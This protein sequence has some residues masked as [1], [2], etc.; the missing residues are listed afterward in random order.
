MKNLRFLENTSN[1]LFIISTGIILIAFVGVMV[2]CAN[3][4]LLYVLGFAVALSLAAFIIDCCIY[5]I[6]TKLLKKSESEYW[7]RLIANAECEE[8]EE[9]FIQKKLEAIRRA[10]KEKY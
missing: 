6:E 8:D 10:R 4:V 1:A 7:N 2:G 3:V 9:A 5:S